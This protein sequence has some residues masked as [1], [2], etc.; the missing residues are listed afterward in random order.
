M[1]VGVPAV[2]ITPKHATRPVLIC[3]GASPRGSPRGSPHPFDKHHLPI[4][5]YWRRHVERPH[6]CTALRK[7]CTAHT[8]TRTLQP[9]AL[10]LRAQYGGRR[11]AEQQRVVSER[12]TS[13]RDH[14]FISP[15]H[16]CRASVRRC[17]ISVASQP[18]SQQRQ[19]RSRS[20]M[21]HGS[22][23]L[24]RL[25]KAISSSGA[26]LRAPLSAQRFAASL[27]IDILTLASGKF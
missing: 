12:R 3:T 5:R 19:S 20:S 22:G 8:F 1:P 13:P 11:Q 24:D 9:Q 14:A 17:E 25:C 27:Q 4:S 2:G 6:N 23:E 18:W 26:E 7:R 21:V 16:K 15:N 10:H